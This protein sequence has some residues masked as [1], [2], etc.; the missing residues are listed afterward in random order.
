MHQQGSHRTIL[1]IGSLLQQS[2]SSCLAVAIHGGKFMA[3]F[4]ALRVWGLGVV[5]LRPHTKKLQQTLAGPSSGAGRNWGWRRGW[6]AVWAGHA[7]GLCPRPCPLLS[8]FWQSRGAAVTWCR[9][10]A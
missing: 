5:M 2:V 4:H 1:P 7:L 9:D 6:R 10:L 8:R 3:H